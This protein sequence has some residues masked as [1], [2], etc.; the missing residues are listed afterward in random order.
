[1]TEVAAAGASGSAA[2]G[3]LPCPPSG[4]PVRRSFSASWAQLVRT[5]P[6]AAMISSQAAAELL[7]VDLLKVAEDR[8][9]ELVEHE[10][11]VAALLEIQV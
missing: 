3:A 4:E 7:H 1:V 2:R 11:D 10:R 6:R 9:I 5:S 8:M